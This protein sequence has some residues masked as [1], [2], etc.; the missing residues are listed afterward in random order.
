MTSDPVSPNAAPGTSYGLVVMPDQEMRKRCGDILREEGVHVVAVEDGHAVKAVLEAR[1]APRVVVTE[2]SLPIV[3]G[4]AM[5]AELRRRF[6]PDQT[7]VVVF[8]AFDQLRNS[9][10]EQRERLGI[11][12]VAAKETGDLLLTHAI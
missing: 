5:I 10:S 2:L 1:G 7:A 3:D 12:W 11:S 6:S 4:F 8:S 9:A